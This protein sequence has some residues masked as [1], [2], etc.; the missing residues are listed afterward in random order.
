MN[1]RERENWIDNDE[2]LYRMWRSSHSAKRKF[3]RS[4]R[5]VIDAV[6]ENVTAGKQ[7][8]H[9]LVYGGK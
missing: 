3:I 8:A 7:P 4:N 1:D 5:S 9:Y 2:G 6:I